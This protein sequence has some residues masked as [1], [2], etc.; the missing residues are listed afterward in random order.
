MGI[1]SL[2]RIA[3]AA[4][5]R[6]AASWGTLSPFLGPRS[7][8]EARLTPGQSPHLRVI[9]LQSSHPLLDVDAMRASRQD[10]ARQGDRVWRVQQVA[11]GQVRIV[12]QRPAGREE[13]EE[14][15]DWGER[16][17]SR[18]RAGSG[19]EPSLG[20]TRAGV[21]QTPRPAAI[22]HDPPASEGI[23]THE[24]RVPVPWSANCLACGVMTP[25]TLARHTP[26]QAHSSASTPT[27]RCVRRPGRPAGL[28]PPAPPP[29]RGWDRTPAAPR[30]PWPTREWGRWGSRERVEGG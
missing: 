4:C 8:P 29:G 19:S 30:S 13:G 2:S 3:A 12:Q 15:R 14:T 21:G 27:R 23:A 6:W 25:P 10:D 26:D 28:P 18:T 17:G 11:A 9:G 5:A 24:R 7:G 1:A 16:L 22:R 20:A